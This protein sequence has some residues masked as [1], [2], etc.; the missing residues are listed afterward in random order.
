M[1]A[2]RNHTTSEPEIKCLDL[3]SIIRNKL[4]IDLNL[5]DDEI[6]SMISFSSKK[7]EEIST[8]ELFVAEVRKVHIILL[9]LL[10]LCL[11]RFIIVFNVHNDISIICFMIIIFIYT[12]YFY[13][14][15]YNVISRR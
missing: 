14:G 4:A 8:L 3:F 9:L 2:F 5:S 12:M 1:N 7:K 6:Q 15:G 13:T 11:C 10:L